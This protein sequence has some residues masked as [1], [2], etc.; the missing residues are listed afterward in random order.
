M[1]LQMLIMS[2]SMLTVLGLINSYGTSETAAAFGAAVQVWTYVQMPVFAIG[3][4]VTAMAAQNIGAGRWERVSQ[5][6]W[7]GAGIN[8]AMT[9]LLIAIVWIFNKQALSLFLP[10]GSTALPIAAPQT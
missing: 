9:G 2:S 6:T 5:T 7:A 10:A 4:A 1:G 8:A 3:A